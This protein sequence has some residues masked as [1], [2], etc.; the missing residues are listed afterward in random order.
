M[1]LQGIPFGSD[2][3]IVILSFLAAGGFWG[4]CKLRDLLSARRAD[5]GQVQ[6]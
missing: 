1:P 4:A 5:R 6:P 2:Q 3:V